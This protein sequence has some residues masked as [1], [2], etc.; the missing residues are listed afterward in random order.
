MYQPGSA[1]NIL[2]SNCSA[3]TQSKQ[4]EWIIKLYRNET[5]RGYTEVDYVKA[6]F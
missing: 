2:V 4:D 5:M 3:S 1:A 6:R